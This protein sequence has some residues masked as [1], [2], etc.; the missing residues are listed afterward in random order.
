MKCCNSIGK[1]TDVHVCEEG[2]NNNDNYNTM[3]VMMVII[4]MVYYNGDVE[5]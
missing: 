5:H 4:L 1:A 3:I 2:Y